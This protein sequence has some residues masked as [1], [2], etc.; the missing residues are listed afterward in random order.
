M[1]SELP[2]KKVSNNSLCKWPIKIAAEEAKTPL[3]QAKKTCSMNGKAKFKLMAT[4]GKYQTSVRLNA[5][6]NKVDFCLRK[7]KVEES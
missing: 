4:S 1:D 3:M 2:T 7:T 5:K 6:V